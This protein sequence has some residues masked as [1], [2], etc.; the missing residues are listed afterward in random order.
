MTTKLS[1]RNFVSDL[2]EGGVLRNIAILVTGAASVQF[3]NL[4]LM[5]LLTRLYGA[6][7]FGMLGLYSSILNLLIVVLGLS[8]PLA[9]VLIKD[10]QE[11]KSMV[12]ITLRIT[13]FMSLFLSVVSCFLAYNYELPFNNVVGYLIL[14]LVPSGFSVVY[15][16]V[17]VKQGKFKSIAIVG[18]TAA[19]V[20]GAAKLFFGLFYLTNVSL[21]YA[22]L[23]G[24]FV[25]AIF[26]HFILYGKSLPITRLFFNSA[27]IAVMGSYVQF[28][29][30]RLPHALNVALSQLVPV[31]LLTHYFGVQAAGYF[32]LTRS[33]LMVPVNMIGKAVYDVAYPKL[34]SDFGN[35]PI[36]LF[37]VGSTLSLLALSFVPMAI[38]FFWGDV[39]FSL[40]FGAEW[41]KAGLYAGCMSFWFAVNFSNRACVAAVSLLK[42]DRFL[43]GNGVVNLIVSSAGFMVGYS[44]WGTDTAAIFLFYLFAMVAQL[45]LIFKVIYEARKID[46]KL[47][48]GG[49]CV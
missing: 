23:I 12:E 6:N 46:K 39:I 45:S 14:G 43:L 47:L 22:V 4:V 49:G 30:Y 15:T 27:D 10:A 24:L 41:S 26:M 36:S 21:I 32:F 29:K 44:I 28:P 7:E 16:Q 17:L 48:Q 40:V 5:P 19:L 13:L 25:N 18:F 8:Y 11:S 38:L 33:V 35:K 31:Y 3:L 34:S 1:G 9:I 20:V 37:L 2:I 42:L